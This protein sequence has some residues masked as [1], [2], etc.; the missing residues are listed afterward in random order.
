[1]LHTS[2]EMLLRSRLSD[3]AREFHVVTPATSES[4]KIWS[5]NLSR[6]QDLWV[7]MGLA[8]ITLTCP[9]SHGHETS[10]WQHHIRPLSIL[11]LGTMHFQGHLGGVLRCMA[12]HVTHQLTKIHVIMSCLQQWPWFEYFSVPIWSLESIGIG[13]L[14]FLSLFFKLVWSRYFPKTGIILSR[15]Q[16]FTFSSA[17]VTMSM[18]QIKM[19]HEVYNSFFLGVVKVYLVTLP[20]TFPYLPKA[21]NKLKWGHTDLPNAHPCTTLSPTA[22]WKRF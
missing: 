12:G 1:M 15:D 22:N 11:G 19:T 4:S 17:A 13:L 14:L 2:Q 5:G 16:K 20:L 8:Q 18:C 3:A 7:S 21:H 10:T 6:N 9:S